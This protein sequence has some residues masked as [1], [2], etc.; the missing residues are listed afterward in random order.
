MMTLDEYFQG[1]ESSMPIFETIR[2]MLESIGPT[3]VRVSMSQVAFWRHKAVARVWIPTCY[4]K[5]EAAPLVLTLGFDHRIDSPRWKEVVE[6][7]PSHFT[8]HLEIWS[9]DDLDEEVRRWLYQAWLEA[10]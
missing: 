4:L 9:V 6:P 5:R 10:A 3:Q 2:D 8:H 1:Y 7:A